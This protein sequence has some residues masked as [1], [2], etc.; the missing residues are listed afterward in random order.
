MDMES[1]RVDFDP[2]A[3]LKNPINVPEKLLM[4]PG[5]SNCSPRVLQACSLPI[6]GHMG[7][8]EFNVILDDIKAGLQYTF[9]TRNKWT[10][11]ISGPGHLG[12]EAVLANLLEPGE[13]IVIGCNGLWGARASETASRLG[14][15]VYKMEKPMGE[16][17]SKVDISDALEKHK[18][19]V[20]FLVHSESSTGVMQSLEGIGDLCQ[21]HN[22]LLVVDAVASLG[23]VPFYM[24]GWKI[25]AVYTGSQK[26]IGAPPGIAPISFS[27][28]AVQVI[29]N[30]ITPVKSFLCDMNLL[31]NY[32]DCNNGEPRIYH[33][34]PPINILF[35]LREALSQV[36][37]EKL[38]NMWSRHAEATAR[39]YRGVRAMGLELFVENQKDR[40][41]TVTTIK[42]P[43]GVDWKLITQHAMDKH[44]IEIAGG[45]G[46][47]V[48]KIVRIGVMG[49]NAYP[50][51][52]DRVLQALKE[53]I[54]YAKMHGHGRARL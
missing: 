31:S 13:S 50:G 52:V 17:F 29:R 42:I 18:P 23:G 54:E 40:L 53:G 24:D 20:L 35:G 47:T 3:I 19:K 26:V 25:D 1:P 27:P 21:S 10:I 9:Q 16:S 37:Q 12:M 5:P 51:K 43:T 36:V 33:H 41:P 45:L 6:I 30:R 34:T 15:C 44:M 46:P 4:G 38:E 7:H 22:C 48:G 11:A 39:L 2:P 49:Y 28:R 32:W 14:A 8:K